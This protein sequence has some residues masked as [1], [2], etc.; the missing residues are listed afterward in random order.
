MRLHHLSLTAFGPFPGTEE[1]DFDELGDAGIFLLT[2]ATGAGKTSILD[3][4]CFALYGVVPGVRG[5]KTLK[6][7]YAD[8]LTR[9]E[10]VLTFSVG[11]R[12]FRL[13][14]S[15][16]WSRPKQRGSGMRTE[17][18]AARLVELLDG[19]HD[20]QHDEGSAERFLTSRAAEVGLH[21]HTL[22]GMGADQFQQV[23]MLPQGGFQTFLHAQ[24]QDR[25]AVLQQ[26]FRTDR[27]ARI[28]DWVHDRSRSLKEATA[29]SETRVRRTLGAIAE[30]AGTDLPEDWQGDELPSLDAGAPL[31]AWA[32]RLLHEAQEARSATARVDEAATRELA[33]VRAAL[34]AGGATFRLRARAQAADTELE[35]LAA[36]RGS[37][38]AAEVLLGRARRAAACAPVIAL[39][40][41][42]SRE[43]GQ[44]RT[45]HARAQEQAAA[46]LG[47]D[48]DVASLQEQLHR[49]APLAEPADRA[50]AERRE[51]R[52]LRAG[53][54]RLVTRRATL[55]TEADGLPAQLAALQQRLADLELEG[56]LLER[57]Q[58]EL[59]AAE[60]T[61]E[62]ADA[63]VAA[64]QRLQELRD[65][66]RD[67]RDRAA[68]ARDLLQDLTQ[69]R[70]D[71]FAAELAGELVADTPCAVCGSPEHPAPARPGRSSV[72]AQEQQ[73]ASRRHDEAQQRLVAAT[74]DAAV[75][76]ERREDLLR[77][78]G[79][80][81]A[82]EAE[83]QADLLRGRLR[84]AEAAAAAATGVRREIAEHDRR[85]E[86]LAAEVAQVEIDQREL[87]HRASTLEEAAARLT[88]ELAAVARRDLEPGDLR[89]ELAR[90]R[91]ALAL[92][93]E[94]TRS[95]D[96]LAQA[97]D[98][99]Q[100]VRAQAEEV[101]AAHDF[102]DLYH[103]REAVLA[104]SRVAELEDAVG[105]WREAWARATAVRHD[106]EV[107]AALTEP[108][109]DLAL[110]RQQEQAADEAAREAA[111]QHHLQTDRAAALDA[112][113]ARLAEEV[114][115][116]LPG[117]QDYVRTE[118][119]SR[120]V[121]GTSGDNQL[122]MRLS[123][124]VLARRLDQV[125]DAAN[126]RL[127]AM[128]DHR[129]L[130]Q[131]TGR[132][133]RKG[134]QAGLGLEVVDQWT[135]EVREPTTLSGGETFVVSLCLALGLADV[136]THEAGGVEVE[137][138]F[139]D[140]GF[141]SLDP[142][143][144]EDVMD[145]LDQLRAG[146]RTVGVVSHVPELRTRIPRQLHVHKT[147]AGSSVRAAVL[148]G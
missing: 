113:V 132:A 29:R 56:A 52:D 128:R 36:E 95:A 27:F 59:A 141:G 87:E 45:A 144:L 104:E 96:V 125:V 98:R 140:E 111:R 3:A 103:A 121:R 21:V 112:L 107:T 147:P 54:G 31:L 44:A 117:Q 139:V 75:A 88:A 76:E 109:A 93:T 81:A 131:R 97:D 25:H 43:A 100:R 23:A 37:V 145:R 18:A 148:V 80:L 115:Q 99:V 127:A 34:E 89:S 15:P 48:D 42:A 32:D 51:A 106:P 24:S 57:L 70:L 55:T 101:A 133:A 7:H 78:A 118:A 82:A 53:L 137:T 30:R 12:R 20:G 124:Y 108:E 110:L 79:G 84:H 40:D 38:E 142:D 46:T 102:A 8:E 41:A 90:L 1:V 39:L 67:A 19:P 33:S 2:G 11:E 6:S 105:G 65:A 22:T 135:G 91:H 28:E 120:L 122:Q 66:V 50:V 77:R 60:A 123:A 13:H 146:G 136:V 83:Q 114:A 73:E 116:W 134:S 17:R 94:A 68:D 35:R 5:V 86:Q 69:R 58:W 138:L 85:S 72:S 74:R 16:E 63:L 49:L 26:L 126:E 47:L 4:V 10:V 62:A 130:L 9:P 119:I 129:Y 14:R 143:T 92:A 64:E 61:H 71:G